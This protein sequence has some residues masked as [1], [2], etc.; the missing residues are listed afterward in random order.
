M[1]K[2]ILTRRDFIKAAAATLG[3][4]LLAA[5]IPDAGTQAGEQASVVTEIS[6]ASHVIPAAP[7]PNQTPE[8]VNSRSRGN[9]ICLT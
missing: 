6:I 2:K 8:P 5:C 1:A 7:A 3:V 4:S 9:L